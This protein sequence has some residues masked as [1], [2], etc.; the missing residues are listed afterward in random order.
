MRQNG[1]EAG[2]CNMYLRTMNSFMS[3]LHAEGHVPT[4]IR[5]KLLPTGDK[6][7]TPFSSADI[8]QILSHK[9]KG[10]WELRTWTIVNVLLDTGCRVDEILK[11]RLDGIDLDNL[12]LTVLGKGN[13][14]RRVPFSPELR[15]V[16]FRYLQAR[17]KAINGVYVFGTRGALPVSYWNVYRDLKAL[18]VKLG[19]S[20]PRVSPHSLRH[21][22]SV[23]YI[24][25]GGH[26]Y[27]LSRIL[28]HTS[29]QTTE[30]YLKTLGVADMVEEHS[31]FSPLSRL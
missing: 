6:V 10:F 12:T 30:I 25:N 23:S 29:T 24:R 21:F 27:K 26:I 3:W 7:F 22:F 19:I 13:K 14:Q 1:V 2:G 15:K 9:P 17:G 20:G 4:R 8:R 5:M 16:V 31:Q 28:G 18:C 11:L